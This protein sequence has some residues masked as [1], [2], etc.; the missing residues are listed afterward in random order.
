PKGQRPAALPREVNELTSSVDLLPA[1]AD[2]L[3]R[4]APPQARGAAIFSGEFAGFTMTE[5]QTCPPSLNDCLLSRAV[6]DD[7]Y[8]LVEYP[9]ETLLFD[10]ERDPREQQ[11]LAERQPGLFDRLSAAAT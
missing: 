2:L 1:L 4:P 5:G 11:S 10:L 3:G 9:G 8:K 6:L 7:T